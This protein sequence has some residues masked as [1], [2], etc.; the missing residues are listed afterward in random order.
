MPEK[1]LLLQTFQKPIALI[2]YTGAQ[3]IN[4]SV[5]LKRYDLIVDKD[6]RIN[7]LKI[8]FAF[9]YRQ[10]KDIKAG[11]TVNKKIEAQQ[12]SLITRIKDR[13]VIVSSGEYAAATGKSVR[14]YMRTGHVITGK[15]LEASKYHIVLQVAGKIVLVYKHG[16][17]RYQ[18]DPTSNTKGDTDV[19]RKTK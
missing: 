9:P 3:L 5:N 17:L 19:R 7:K 13:P 16:I 10:Y 2:T 11:I 4:K 6:K 14:I 8:M 15:Q 12:L 18:V 1:R